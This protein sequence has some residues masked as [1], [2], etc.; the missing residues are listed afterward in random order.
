MSIEGS[1]LLVGVSAGLNSIH[2]II[3]REEADGRLRLMGEYRNRQV[4]LKPDETTLI[5]RVHESIE[6]AIRDAHVD[7][8]DI[9]AIGVASPGQIDI[10]N[11]MVLFSPLFEVQEYPFPFVARLR[12]HLDVHHIVLINNDD[13]P[14]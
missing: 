9:L 2:T 13:A 14:G 4:I 7:W 8:A 1:Q 11:G 5:H 3:L 6:N 12:D 10:D